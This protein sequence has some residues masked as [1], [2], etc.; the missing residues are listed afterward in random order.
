MVP[1]TL[2][3][4]EEK[5]LE[6]M[7]YWK[8]PAP[9]AKAIAELFPP[10]DGK[11]LLFELDH[12]GFNNIRLAF[13][14]VVLVAMVTGRTLV[15]PPATGWYLFDWGPMG[16]KENERGIKDQVSPGTLSE[17]GDYWDEQALRRVLGGRCISI[18]LLCL[19]ILCL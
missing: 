10:A 11:Y 15:L 2:T 17:V 13:E 18:G 8:E 1:V 9:T 19:R 7:S 4:A 14:T 6:K 16:S 12:G 3:P 5:V